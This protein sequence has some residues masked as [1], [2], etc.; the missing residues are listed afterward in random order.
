MQLM[1][2]GVDTCKT[3]PL[4]YGQQA[5]WFL[6]QL[7]PESVAY[8]I[9]FT[10]RIRTHVDTLAL[11]RVFQILI[12]RYPS[13]STTFSIR[14]GNP[15]QEIHSDQDLY[16]EELDASTWSCDDLNQWVVDA[17]KRS[18]N[19]IQG[20]ILRVSLLTLSEQEHILLVSL[21]HTVC[22]EWFLWILLDE[23]RLLYPVEKVGSTTSL[24]P[25]S[26]QYIDYVQW[27]TE[28]LAGSTGEQL[29]EYW[30][31]QLAGELPIL[32]LPIDLPRPPM[33]TYKG[34]SFAFKLTEELAQQLYSL[35]QTEEVDP[36]MI[37]LSALQVLLYRYTAQEDTLVGFIK[38]GSEETKFNRTVGYFVNPV[39]LRTRF[40][41]KLTFKT[42]L[43]QVRSTVLAAIAHQNY[44]FPLLVNQL[45]PTRDTSRSPLFQ[46][47]FVFHSPQSKELA[48][49]LVPDQTGARIN[50]GD[51]ELEPLEMAQQEGQF[52]LTLEIVD[53]R[54]TILGIL[55]YNTDLFNSATIARIAGNL[56][57]LL[58]SIVVN[59]LQR[60]F[61]LPILSEA[62]QN[63]LLLEWNN[64]QVEYPRNSCIHQLFHAQA[65]RT[66]DAVAVVFENQHLTY[67]ELNRQAN[68]LANYLQTLGVGPEVLVGIC[69]ERSLDIWDF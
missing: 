11:R 5:L 18:F 3:Y 26:C 1:Q 17:Y 61:Q 20:P 15:V 30:R 57:T 22:D 59:P 43:S 23:L 6:H 56:Q 10:T 68:Q 37:F 54:E 60:L 55:K 46:V 34:A 49:L 42:F 8:N 50:W 48:S 65:E 64:T 28:M 2:K 44:P 16:F 19:L 67:R 62:E 12:A 47:S 52:D 69:T 33:Q 38:S 4:S 29:W 14:S 7:A 36:Y 41:E 39:V 63:Q 13:L 53:T 21:H 31:K 66:P 51:L 45:K 24:P 9:A 40:S 35:A 58:E 25:I 32:N 27:Q